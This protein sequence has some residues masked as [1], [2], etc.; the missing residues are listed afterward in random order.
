M[1]SVRYF[2]DLYQNFNINL[3]SNNFYHLKYTLFTIAVDNPVGYL[4][5]YIF[6]IFMLIKL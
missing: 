2:N 1:E 5:F 6:N 3:T 4:K